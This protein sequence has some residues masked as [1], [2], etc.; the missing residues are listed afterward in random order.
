MNWFCLFFCFSQQTK[1]IH[2]FIFWENLRRIQT[3]FGFIWPLAQIICHGPSNH[4]NYKSRIFMD[5]SV[6][7]SVRT[8]Q[9]L[10]VTHFLFWLTINFHTLPFLCNRE[11]SLVRV[12]FTIIKYC[13]CKYEA[14]NIS[15]NL[16]KPWNL[17]KR[18]GA[19]FHGKK[20]HPREILAYITYENIFCNT[21]NQQT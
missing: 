18:E 14:Y 19:L 12:G 8:W 2:S 11:F 21:T 13:Y 10:M 15:K 6:K 16:S 9:F 17:S 4:E 7:K 20:M 1:Q 5:V 3:A